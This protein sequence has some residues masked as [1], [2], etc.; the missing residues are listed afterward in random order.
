MKTVDE[1]MSGQ[2]NSFSTVSTQQSVTENPK[3]FKQPQQLST[4]DQTLNMMKNSS[5]LQKNE[6]DDDD[7]SFLS[8]LICHVC[9][10][11]E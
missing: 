10:K 1:D 8:T 5:N 6:Q 9:Q 2:I 7:S 4:F 3:K 11:K